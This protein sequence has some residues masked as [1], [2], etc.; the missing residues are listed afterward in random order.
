MASD[1]GPG[2][3][4][5]GGAQ[6]VLCVF[7]DSHA[8]LLA[9]TMKKLIVQAKVR[10]AVAESSDKFLNELTEGRLSAIVQAK[11]CTHAVVNMGQWSTG[12]P[13]HYPDPAK[14]FQGDL[15]AVVS[16]LGR[17]VASGAL[18]SA[19]FVSLNY[20]PA[21][22]MIGKCPPTD[23]RSRPF[24]DAYNR[25]ISTVVDAEPNVGHI[26]NMFIVDPMWDS[27][28]DWCH[29]HGRVAEARV[30]HIAQARRGRAPPPPPPPPP[31]LP[32]PPPPPSSLAP[33]ASASQHQQRQQEAIARGLAPV[34]WVADAACGAVNFGGNHGWPVCPKLLEQ[35]ADCVVYAIGIGM[36][37]EF[38]QILASRYGCE[39]H[40]F[41]PSPTGRDAIAKLRDSGQM[42]PN[43]HYHD[44]G[45]S[46]FD[47]NLTLY[48]SLT[49]VMY[50]REAPR[51]TQTSR[52][53]D[54]PTL[55]CH[56]R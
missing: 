6:A 17:L 26:D 9:G 1:N 11:K 15:K 28:D 44:L 40:S 33:T 8:R 48:S 3:A 49:G 5:T 31:L 12:W 19:W 34:P 50:T 20:N 41:D 4:G 51:E 16:I 23:W 46:D 32:P 53:K 7:G 25:V 27:A 36:Y 43:M 13:N 39:V 2:L 45:I 38:D 55:R 30:L 52:G 37:P 29:Y 10:A 42:P 56:F 54:A 14:T 47:G 24:I 35:T 21:G 18:A 22:A